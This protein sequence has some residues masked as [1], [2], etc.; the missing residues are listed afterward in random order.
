ML[1]CALAI[2]PA[3][4]I[5]QPVRGLVKLTAVSNTGL[6]RLRVTGNMFWELSYLC[7]WSCKSFLITLTVDVVSSGLFGS[8][9]REC[10]ETS[11]MDSRLMDIETYTIS[12]VVVL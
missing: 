2:C 10:T 3:L 11:V 5:D 8:L 6:Y 4:G 9:P 1:A 7:F 12:Q